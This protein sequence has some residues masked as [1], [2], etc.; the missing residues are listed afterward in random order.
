MK[1]C[2]KYNYDDDRKKPDDDKKK[3]DKSVCIKRDEDGLSIC[4]NIYNT[5]NLANQGGNAGFKQKAE[6]GGQNS[7]SDGQSANQG[8]QIAEKCGQN[9][10]QDGEV[11][12]QGCGSKVDGESV[13]E[14]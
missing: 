2:Y 6:N 10:N 4:I 9:A 12:S 3:P 5:N 11:E 7:G 8:G 13:M 14:D 1:T